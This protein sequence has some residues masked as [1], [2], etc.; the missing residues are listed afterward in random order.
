[1]DDDDVRLIVTMIANSDTPTVARNTGWKKRRSAT[2][3]LNYCSKFLS[4]QVYC[5]VLSSSLDRWWLM[6]DGWWRQVVCC[7][8]FEL[9]ERHTAEARIRRALLRAHSKGD[10]LMCVLLPVNSKLSTSD[11]T[12]FCGK[13]KRALS[14]VA[15][16][17]Q[18]ATVW[19]VTTLTHSKS[20][21][22]A[23][24]ALG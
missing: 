5:T 23:K 14:G 21:H 3:L 13:Q 10:E 11:A 2:I 20:I 4:G 1:M 15:M 24:Q 22:R 12:F 9:L 18:S 19:K 8:C 7:C 6:A 17:A 16:A